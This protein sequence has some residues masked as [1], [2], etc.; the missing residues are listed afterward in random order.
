MRKINKFIQDANDMISEHITEEMNLYDLKLNNEEYKYY[1]K[2]AE[3]KWNITWNEFV[4]CKQFIGGKKFE[5]ID[6]NDLKS[7]E[8]VYEIF[9]TNKQNNS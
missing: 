4:S 3:E 7:M 1:A 8:E 6:Q 2:Y 9:V 5:K